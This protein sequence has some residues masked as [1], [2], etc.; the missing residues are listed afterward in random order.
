MIALNQAEIKRQRTRFYIILG[1]LVLA[2][3]FGGTLAYLFVQKNKANRKLQ[4][5]LADLQRAQDQL[6]R[7]EK[8]AS[9]GQVT[10]GIAHEIRNPLNFV[11][12]L[13][14]LSVGMIDEVEEELED[15]KGKPLENQSAN[16]LFEYFGDIKDN[17]KKVLEHGE[18]A[19]RIVR[20]MLQHAATESAEKLPFAVNELVEEYMKVAY[21]SQPNRSS[22]G[23]DFNCELEFVPDERIGELVG[24]RSDIG[25]ALLNILTNA[26]EA[27]ALRLEQEGEGYA[28]HLTVRTSLLGK[29]VQIAIADNG[30]GIAKEQLNRIF[31]PF[32]T[33]KPPNKGTGLGLSLAHETIVRTH[34][35]QL[36]VSSEA[37]KGT[38]FRILLP[39]KG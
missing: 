33:T 11:T 29:Q 22:T 32:F 26:F 37:G 16:L 34:G 14:K 38:E 19:G 39:V 20:D 35:G 12:N 24:I 27:M 7:S 23:R 9:L 28:P 36:S 3:L 18:R 5:A 21:H 25:R 6:V 30:Q 13:S 1:G 2:L 8:M 17:T 10:A 31:D 4:Q 15:A